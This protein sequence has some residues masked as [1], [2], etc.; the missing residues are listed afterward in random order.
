MIGNFKKNRD[1]RGCGTAPKYYPNLHQNSIESTL[2]I[3]FE[4]TFNVS[5]EK[6]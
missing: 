4:S 2:K 6:L 1:L 3:S 5:L